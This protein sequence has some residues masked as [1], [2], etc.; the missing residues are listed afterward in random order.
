MSILSLEQSHLSELFY[1]CSLSEHIYMHT[2]MHT[3]T[4]YMCVYVCIYVCIHTRGL[5]RNISAIV[6]VTRM[7]CMTSL[8][9]GSQAEWTRMLMCEQ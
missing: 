6:N 4:P 1:I 2:Y 3:Y 8:K 5:S 9:A 7:I